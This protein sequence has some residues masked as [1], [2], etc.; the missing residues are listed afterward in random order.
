MN[1]CFS[2]A[3]HAIFQACRAYM[4]HLRYR[5]A[6]SEA[7]KATFRFMQIVMENPFKKSISYFDQARKKR[8]LTL[9]D[10]AGVINEKEAEELLKRARKFLEHTESKLKQK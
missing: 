7:N 3:C 10:D 2:I 6:N 5:P 4:F 8:H 9:Y 1:W